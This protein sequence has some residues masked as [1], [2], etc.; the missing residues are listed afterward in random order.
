MQK[1]YTER[2]FDITLENLVNVFDPS[3]GVQGAFW[4]L[5]FKVGVPF[6][7]PSRYH[8]PKVDQWLEAA[9]TEID[10]IK[11]QQYFYDFQQALHDD[12]ASIELGAPPSILI[13]DKRLRD[14]DLSAQSIRD[15]FAAV[16]FA[17]P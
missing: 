4:S 17:A 9:A 2:A 15:S 12:L 5:S 14:V 3:I 11:R 7:N 10:P 16:Y 8:N 6:A 1:V 13:A